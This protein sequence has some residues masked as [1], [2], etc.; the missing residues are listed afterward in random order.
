M[1]NGA[2][3]IREL[4]DRDFA[5]FRDIIY[6]ESRIKLSEMKKALVQARLMMR[7]RE[8]RLSDYGEYYDYLQENYDAEIVNLIN[9]I[10]TNKTD[11]FRE[12]KHFDFLREVVFP[13]FRASGKKKMRIWSAG[14]STGEE[15]YTIAICVLDFFGGVPQEDI[16]ILATDIDTAVLGVAEKG[17]YKESILETV[18]RETA[19][20][21][22]LRGTGVN[23]GK[24]RVR[25][26]VKSLVRFRK[27]NLLEEH[28]PMSG[29]FDAIFCRNVIIYFDKDTQRTLFDRFHRYVADDGYLFVGHSETLAGVTD[30]FTF[31][32]STIYRKTQVTGRERSDVRT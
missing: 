6:E 18:E 23:E 28:Y 30:K 2:F 7:L 12:S 9:C 29:P 14:C 27:L 4:G 19:R 11:F 17:V 20:R 32:K 21:Y 16:K 3:T 31:I 22:F 5:K 10:T 1:T 13:Q 8:L 26:E 15:P 24:Y 25:D